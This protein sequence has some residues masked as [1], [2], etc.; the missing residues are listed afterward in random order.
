MEKPISVAKVLVQK[1]NF[2]WSNYDNRSSTLGIANIVKCLRYN[3]RYVEG[4]YI[5]EINIQIENKSASAR[6][7]IKFSSR[8]VNYIYYILQYIEESCGFHSITPKRQT[9]DKIVIT[10]RFRLQDF[11]D[12]KGAPTLKVRVS[13]YSAIFPEKCVKFD[14]QRGAHPQRSPWICQCHSYFIAIFLKV[15]QCCFF[16][17]LKSVKNEYGVTQQLSW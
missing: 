12:E 6:F 9:Y 8:E 16:F 3:E 1:Q 4:R 11:P 15:H 5:N 14:R 10:T 7:T 2:S 17:H 13:T